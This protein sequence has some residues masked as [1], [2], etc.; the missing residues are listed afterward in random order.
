MIPVKY[1]C[2]LESLRD[3]EAE[4]EMPPSKKLTNKASIT[5]TPAIESQSTN[6]LN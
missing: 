6:V 2:D 4:L 3:T 1:E 5:T